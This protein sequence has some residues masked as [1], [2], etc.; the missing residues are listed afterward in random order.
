MWILFAIASLF[1]QAVE[2]AV[3]KIAIVK[4]KTIDLFAATVVRNFLFWL[5]IAVFGIAGFLGSLKI[6]L[7]WPILL[8]AVILIGGG[9]FYT[10][11]LKKIELTESAA[12]S[13]VSPALYL[14]IDAAL[15]KL[16]FTWLQAMGI[17]L[18]TAGGML[19]VINVKGGGIKE[20]FTPQV[21]AIFV[22]NFLISG[23]QYYS[24]KYFFE[25]QGLNEV[26]YYFNI[27]LV[28]LVMFLVIALVQNRWSALWRAAR[29]HLY[30]DKMLLSKGCDAFAAYLWL[31]ALTL[32]SVSQVNAIGSIYPLILIGSL[33]LLQNVFKFKAEE[34]FSKGALSLKLVAVALLCI[35][36]FLAK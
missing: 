28:M 13:Y 23:V 11:L 33:Y 35:G 1:F 12:L 36:G 18:L 19:F 4:D 21:W 8:L 15:L 5:W 16:N 20:E 22:Y 14:I 29:E 7:T 6:M 25:T 10:Y 34:N 24:F 3:D 9:F 30:F 27:W 32:A 17:L 2:E 31:H 26:S